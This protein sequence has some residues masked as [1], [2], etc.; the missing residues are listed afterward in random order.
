MGLTKKA[1]EAP[2]ATINIEQWANL[3]ES[4]Y[5]QIKRIE[6]QMKEAK[7]EL[8]KYAKEHRAEFDNNQLRFP[9]GVYV[10]CRNRM[11]D[12]YEEEAMS[13][14]WL[15]RFVE[16]GGGDLVLVK[17]DTKKTSELQKQSLVDLLNEIG[18]DIEIKESLA[19]CTEK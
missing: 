4:Y 1:V 19:V 8:L 18:Y 13:L 5:T 17:F 12:N 11:T 16:N 3:Y 9:N 6:K 7:D 2:K 14:D 15:S 10:E